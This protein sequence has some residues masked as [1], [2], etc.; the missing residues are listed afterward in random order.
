MMYV[1]NY[2]KVES[3]G[4]FDGGNTPIW[5]TFRSLARDALWFP[6]LID[7]SSATALSHG[8]NRCKDCIIIPNEREK[9]NEILLS[10]LNIRFLPILIKIQLLLF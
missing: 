9:R 4:S 2:S 3:Q 10:K 1:R 7:A 5:E 6:I 8:S